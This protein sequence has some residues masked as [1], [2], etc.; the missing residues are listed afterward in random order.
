MRVLT[1]N[2]YTSLKKA[3][4]P[5]FVLNLTTKNAFFSAVYK[6][7]LLYNLTARRATN[8]KGLSILSYA[9]GITL[10]T[11]FGVSLSKLL[12]TKFFKYVIKGYGKRYI[13]VLKGL[14]KLD[15][16]PLVV[17][18]VLDVAHNGCRWK[19]ARR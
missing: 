18:R 3:A 4:A 19:K 8:F 5:K 14:F 13:P 7:L 12:P 10:G 1:S 17:V 15:F 11:F 2:K 16:Q 9:A 6:D